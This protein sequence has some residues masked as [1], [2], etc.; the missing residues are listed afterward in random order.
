MKPE[1]SIVFLPVS[2]IE[3]TVRFYRDTLKLPV[4]QKQ[5]DRLYIFDTGYGYWGFCQY[6]DDR[7]PLSGPQGVC[8]SLNL[9]DNEAV[10][11][12]YEELK[13]SSR[14][15]KRPARHPQFPVYSFFLMDP[16]EYL[17]EFQKIAEL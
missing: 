13:N 7:K 10:I 4:H 6:D 12:K 5:S 9:P 8:L 14:V 15:Y 3:E 17:V 2:D 1:S 11:N 16:D